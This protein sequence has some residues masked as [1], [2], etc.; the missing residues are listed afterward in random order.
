MLGMARILATPIVMGLL[1]LPFAGGGLLALVLFAAAAITDNLDG[2]IARARRQVSPLGVFMDLTADKVLVAGV[3]VAMVEVDL[4][5]AWMV[6]LILIRELVIAGVRQLAA[7]EDVVM[8]AGQ[9]GKWKTT[10]TLLAMG[11][12]LLAFDARTGGPASS[13]GATG[14]IGD[15]GFWLMVLATVLTVISGWAYLRA[16][17]PI[18]SGSEHA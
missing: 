10:A 9:L 2:R 1:L 6:A 11:V 18:L 15:I 13:L 17:W 7:S 12:L 4:L 3:L 14:L 5:P 8:A 16:A